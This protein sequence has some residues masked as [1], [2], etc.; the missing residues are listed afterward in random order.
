[1]LR[2]SPDGDCFI[3]HFL[4][5][6]Q[7]THNQDNRDLL[8]SFASAAVHVAVQGLRAAR[9]TLRDRAAARRQGKEEEAI[10]NLMA[11]RG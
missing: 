11:T 2:L 9:P 5:P 7:G 3:I 1:M 8:V 6:R 4:V 10:Q